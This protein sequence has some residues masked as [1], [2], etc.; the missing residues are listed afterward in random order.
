MN[1]PPFSPLG[2]PISAALIA[3]E[4]E[5]HIARLHDPQYRAFLTGLFRLAMEPDD[6]LEHPTSYSRGR[7]AIRRA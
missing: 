5:Q 3:V 6:D 1:A 2:P 4:I 7:K